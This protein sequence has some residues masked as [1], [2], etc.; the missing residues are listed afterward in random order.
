MNNK[1]KTI[2]K[3]AV[4][5]L[6]LL[7]IVFAIRIPAS[8]IPGVPSDMK[9]EY[10]DS[11]GLPYFSEMDSY[12]NLRMTQDLVDH[13]Y[14]GDTMV[15][16]TQVDNHRFSPN[17]MNTTYTPGIGY[18][19]SF[20]YD[21]A[22]IF[23]HFDLKTVAFWTGSIIACLAVIPAYIIVRR[24]T[25]DYGAI[26]ASLI[27]TLSPNYFAHTFPGFFDTDMFVFV[28]PLF[29]V[30]FFIECI[31]SNNRI[32]KI[33]YAV[34]A[35]LSIM[36]FAKCWDGYVFYLGM[37]AIFVI[38]YLIAN[39]YFTLRDPNDKS[40]AS[41]KL[42]NFFHQKEVL[43][44]IGLVV[45][46]IIG[47]LIVDGAGVLG[48]VSSV[49][50]GF[51]LQASTTATGFP[52]VMVSVAELQVPSLSNGG[53]LG[54]FLAST[55]SVVSGVG[56]IICFLAALVVLYTYIT[57]FSKLRK[58]TTKTT[59]TGKLPKN[60]RQS[61]SKRTEQKRFEFSLKEID[62]FGSKDEIIQSRKE[63]LLY[64]TLFLVWTIS[65]CAAVTQGSRFITLLILPFGLLSGIFV[66]Y[67]VDYIKSKRIDD[68]KLAATIVIA[69]LLIAYPIIAQVDR[70]FGIVVLIVL[71]MLTVILFD[72]KKPLVYKDIPYKKYL[73]I[74]CIFLAIVSPTVC[75][76]YA[77]SNSVVPGT[78][79]E[80]WD[81]M[82]WI[83]QN[84]PNDTVI[85]S[86]WDFGY[87]FEIAA[88]RQTMFD[89]GMQG[90]E[91][92]AYWM[93]E[94]MTTDNLEL[95][96]GIFRMLGTSGYDSIYSVLG[97]YT[98]N[99]NGTAVEIL[100]NILPQSKSDAKNT[101]TNQYKV[102]SSDADQVL[103]YTH[104]DNPRPVIFVASSDMLQKAG[105][106]TY[107]GSW[108][109]DGEET[110][111][112]QY[113][114]S[115]NQT[116]IMPG[117]SGKIDMLDEN[118]INVSVVV[119]RG[120]RN[121]TTTAYVETRFANNNS[122]ANING[123]EY[124]PLK[125][126]NILVV[127]DNYLVKNQTISNGT[128]GNYTLYLLG[129]NN[130][131]MAVLMSNELVDSMFTRLY[132]L[133]GNGQ[134]IFTQVHMANGVSLWKVNFNNTVAGGGSGSSQSNNT[135]G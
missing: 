126:S 51:A 125:A 21:L 26:A 58:T 39:F 106:W 69:I 119:N 129:S 124:N 37:L 33:I 44:V 88:D 74:F 32:H 76:A 55:G 114:P 102:S 99:S 127:E 104:P 2:I 5:I 30:L 133:G 65:A 61:T 24:I 84:E 36:L 72:V 6:I 20:M 82:V 122:I 41:T 17:G 91:G 121:N 8:D 135:T 96:A 81:S 48:I 66:G 108:K 110:E 59:A 98:N 111:Q 60:L 29:I 90:T 3:S 23:G 103:K 120:T 35:V 10:V 109:F 14:F 64:L 45:L 68:K 54:L 42:S 113:Y 107:F 83:Q 16:N 93:G 27:I 15:N 56:G 71:L 49:L 67:A 105:W 92:R 28:F 94:A 75:C 86:W 40:S 47:L 79:D 43:S 101:L 18:A 87:L 53:V 12:Y 123:T 38:I 1:T 31:R 115:K 117:H 57:R 73:A 112:Y 118:G 85:A 19:T 7:A 25:N 116:T 63:T 22:N 100:N 128:D 89:G 52:N 34:L 50:S 132:L 97:K 134:D 80:M 78:N 4:I 131:Y 95:S 11:S 13:G 62:E 9:A 77:T 46:L 130:T 70:T